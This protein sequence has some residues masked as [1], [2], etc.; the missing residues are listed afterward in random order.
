MKPRVEV[1]NRLV[2]INSVSTLGARL[3]TI[4]V[5]FW[6]QKYLIDEIGDQGFSVLPVVLAIMMAAPLITT[7]L[8]GGLGRFI[9]EADAR[10]DDRR[11]TEIVSTMFPILCAAAAAF[12]ALGWTVSWFAGPLLNIGPEY[13]NEA[14]LMLAILVFS[15]TV[16]LVVAPFSLG[17]FVR[18]KF[19]LENLINVATELFRLGLLFALLFGVSIRMLW[20]V[21]A[22]ATAEITNL[23]LLQWLSRRMMPTLR[24]NPKCIHWGTAR[25]L[26]NFGG[27]MTL[28]GVASTIRRSADV[29][30]LNWF[31]RPLEVNLFYFGQIPKNQMAIFSSQIKRTVLPIITS[32]FATGQMDKVRRAYLRASRYALWIAT[33][34]L[35]P[36]LLYGGNAF[37]FYL[38]EEKRDCAIVMNM[39]LA[40]YLFAWPSVLT[41]ELAQASGKMRRLSLTEFS[42][43]ITNL[44]LTFYAVGYLKLGAFGS[45]I[46]TLL[47]TAVFHPVLI[48]PLGMQLAGVSVRDMARGVLLPGLAPGL[49]HFGLLGIAAWYFPE[50]PLWALLA[51]CTAGGI[52]HMACVFAM[53]WKLEDPYCLG[54]LDKLRRK[55][56]S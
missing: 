49:A 34:P 45:A 47:V 40:T 53:G 37:V 44:V 55:R 18:Q 54:L 36:G 28:S 30:I 50:P 9:V 42:M 27:W 56:R 7:V 26:T 21:V 8:T 52:F 32:C 24:F 46:A 4:L 29:P 17:L 25:E 16:R 15:A 20:P 12:L 6:V 5:L 11:V 2:L 19:V 43:H 3:L 13:V 1:S 48:W 35:V 23:L 14:R 39:L 41:P 38:G 22:T 31:A 33:L 51:L 10:K